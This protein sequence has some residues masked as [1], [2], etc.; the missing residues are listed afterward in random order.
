MNR[1]KIMLASTGQSSAPRAL[2]RLLSQQ[3]LSSLLVLSSMTTT[4]PA[5]PINFL[6]V[7]PKSSVPAGWVACAVLNV[8]AQP[9]QGSSC[10]PTD[11][12]GRGHR[13]LVTSGK[14]VLTYALTA[15]VLHGSQQT[16]QPG[17]TMSLVCTC[18]ISYETSASLNTLIWRSIHS[19]TLR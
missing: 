13:T 15:N 11:A 8:Q 10:L 17:L 5:L 9:R 6:Q 12:H 4:L 14:S 18:V 19:P 2:Q 1:M 3:M 7:S 16:T